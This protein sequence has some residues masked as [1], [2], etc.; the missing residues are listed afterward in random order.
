MFFP[1]PLR[2]EAGAGPNQ[3]IVTIGGA[4]QKVD[5]AKAIATDKLAGTYR[6]YSSSST[7]FGGS[8][9]ESAITFT[10]AGRFSKSS[11]GGSYGNA[12]TMI[13]GANTNTTFDD[14]GSTLSARGGGVGVEALNSK[15]NPRGDREGTYSA[16]GYALTLR[17]DNGKVERL[18]LL[19]LFDGGALWL[20][21]TRMSRDKS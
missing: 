19:K 3:W 18:P 15:N 13:G 12:A 9:G 2:R 5:A 16:N 10:S 8:Y 11:Y 20:D 14:D 6:A 7:V 1:H 4:P 21:G 17:Y